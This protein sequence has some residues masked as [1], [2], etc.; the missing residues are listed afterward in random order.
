MTLPTPTP[1]P[2]PRR[3]FG[4]YLSR[5]IALIAGLGGILIAAVFVIGGLATG[6]GAKTVPA[7][8]RRNEAR[9]LTMRDGVRIAIDVWVPANLGA[10]AKVPTLIYSTR[11]TRALQFG[12]IGKALAVFGKAPWIP[13]WVDQIN[14]AGYVAVLVDARGSGASFGTR[15]TEWSRDEVA[16]LGEVVDWVVAQGWSSGKV[17]G[18]GVSY[19]GNTAELLAATGRK[20]VKAV[21]PLFDDYD[22]IF[23]QAKAGGAF[24]KPFIDA[25]GAGNAATD[26]NDLCRASE[27]TGIKCFLQSLVVRSVKPVDGD[28]GAALLAAAVAEHRANYSVAAF[29]AG[30]TYPRDSLL[31][32]GTVSTMVAPYLQAARAVAESNQVAM[33]IR[34]GWYDGGTMNTGVG[35]FF[36]QSNPMTIEIGAWNHG[37]SAN[38]DP[39]AAPDAAP[40]PSAK[41]QWESMVRFFDT[42][43][44]G[45]G[46]PPIERVI[47]YYTM[48]EGTWKTTTTWPPEN[49][50]A[51]RWFFGAA[52]GLSPEAPVAD[53]GVDQYPVD[54]TATTG[55][56]SRWDTQL[57]GGDVIYPDRA[58]EDRKLLTY[59]SAPLAADLEITG[60]PILNLE[61]SSTATDGLFIGYLEDVA[62]DGRVTYLTEGLLRALHR[63][64]ATAPPPYH[65][66]GPVHLFTSADGAPLVPN[67]PTM[68]SFAM[69]SIS[70]RLRAGHRIRIAIAGH[71]TGGFS[72][73]PAEGEAAITVFRQRGRASWI[74]LPTSNGPH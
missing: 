3:P 66:F 25:W 61:V 36:T 67:E 41:E 2:T 53:S 63:K 70:V 55:H 72:R 30:L 42:Y 57:G 1:T 74:D 52:N 45:D 71:D 59:T 50:T 5:G 37:G 23:T 13:D 14:A 65:E 68:I 56:P 54:F 12:V 21:A 48:N 31:P 60:V 28:S 8:L 22:P 51:R 27:I 33:L 49:V 40:V 4:W 19:D 38:V 73:I 29:V 44:K 20:A 10:D 6:P 64:V 43:L 32:D 24:G 46:T 18:W 39:F 35:R 11:Y 16:D 15:A 9:Y 47:R 17:G 34:L 62:P 58:A 26:A 7:G 69:Y